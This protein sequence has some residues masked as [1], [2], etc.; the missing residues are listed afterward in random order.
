MTWFRTTRYGIGLHWR[1]PV[2][3]AALTLA[4]STTTSWAAPGYDLDTVFYFG[5][6]DPDDPHFYPPSGLNNH[7]A[8]V[9]E[10][11]RWQEPWYWDGGFMGLDTWTRGR[12]R[13]VS[14]GGHV[15]GEEYYSGG[16][17]MWD[18]QGLIGLP[19]G[20]AAVA[21]NGDVVGSDDGIAAVW[22][23]ANQQVVS[24]GT[25][26]GAASAGLG[27]N[28]SGAHVGR[29][30]IV[31]GI[32]H[33]FLQQFRR[34]M[35]DL[36]D[37]LPPDTPWVL[38]E[39][40]DINA[41][42]QIVG[43]GTLDGEK[44]AFLLDGSEVTDLGP[45]IGDTTDRLIINNRGEVLFPANYST[46][47]GLLYR[48]GG[49]YDVE[50]VLLPPDN[51]WD[52]SSVADLNDYGDILAFATADNTYNSYPVL[53]HP[54][55]APFIVVTTET[56]VVPEGETTNVEVSLGQDP[57]GPITVTTAFVE[58]DADLSIVA[59]AQLSFDPS[60]W[61]VKQVITLAA[62][63]DDDTLD[64]E[65]MFEITGPGLKPES[66]TVVEV[67]DDFDGVFFVDAAADGDGTGVDW[68]N[69][70]T[71]LQV[72]LDSARGNSQ[73]QEI[74]L[75]Q[76]TYLPALAGGD[77][78]TSFELVP[79]V[80]VLGG[81]AGVTEPDPD[82]RDPLAYPTI[83]SGDIDGDGTHAGNVY[84]VVYGLY[85]TPAVTLDGV[86]VVQGQSRIAF[87][88]GELHLSNCRFPDDGE[89]CDLAVSASADPDTS[90]VIT[91]DR[92]EISGQ[93]GRYGRGA[94]QADRYSQMEITNSL[95]LDNVIDY[96]HADANGAAIWIRDAHV[97][98]SGCEFVG[99][100]SDNGGA[101]AVQRDN[102]TASLSVSDCLFR[103]NE[104]RMDGGAIMAEANTLVEMVNCE[105]N[106]NGAAGSGGTIVCDTRDFDLIN[107]TFANNTA[108]AGGAV[109]CGYRKPT[110]RNS[111][112]WNNTPNQIDS[113]SGLTVTHSIIQGGHSGDG[114]LDVDPN[115]VDLDG[116]DGI[117]G[118][119][120]DDLRLAAGSPA[121]DAAD[122]T[123][124]PDGV[125]FDLDGNPRF[126]DDPDTP[127][128]GVPGAPGPIV[129]M[130]AYEYQPGG[131]IPGDLNG[132]G[133]V[134]QADLGTLLASYGVDDGGD[135]DGD[136][137][138]DQA[139]LGELLSHYGDGC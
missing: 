123:Q 96:P 94:V 118:N 66:L 63:P 27:L 34:N 33:A 44:R 125:V 87:Y 3:G 47:A 78:I 81:Y 77:P 12:V 4:L 24:L 89:Q 82:A 31:D 130:G 37:R 124:V 60:N 23:Y 41:L 7:G 13:D 76:G 21:A 111:I 122:N 65:A 103:D 5:P 134:D 45:G 114:N 46:P 113:P 62:A 57:G 49:F 59:G 38:T 102:A 126:V 2:A 39:A 90:A 138:T 69:A 42:G 56:I 52:L 131:D 120:D 100:Q 75:A 16:T 84:R 97:Q 10:I 20:A 107:G 14:D 50:S 132:D 51:G 139:D 128:T 85:L 86:T 137:D 127:D 88:S 55:D 71:D 43:W 117:P 95:F 92:C 83:L 26:G 105:F 61:S 116:P 129:D 136:G 91:I 18:G 29:A 11:A 8:V 112:L 32:Y 28:D 25:L 30:Q 108:A 74:R 101:I 104:A 98:V 19:I 119:A 73:V 133:C 35:E 48:A 110:I 9:G 54:D 121:I 99:N 68:G 6:G 106:G 79:G 1:A 64:G 93:W 67:D 70:M 135:I 58:G 80:D 72:A 15:I 17:V 115:F 53:L 22:L 36:N 40:R 109:S